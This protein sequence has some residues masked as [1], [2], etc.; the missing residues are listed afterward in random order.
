MFIRGHFGF[1][2]DADRFWLPGL[3][4]AVQHGPREIGLDQALKE[5]RGNVR[6]AV[7]CDEQL[8]ATQT[9]ALTSAGVLRL[10]PAMPRNASHDWKRPGFPSYWISAECGRTTSRPSS[11]SSICLAHA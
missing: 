7:I 4:Q 8:P 3:A 10:V 11:G 5:F 2:A 1:N 9:V 6:G